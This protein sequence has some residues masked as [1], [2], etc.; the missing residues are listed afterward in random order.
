MVY[1]VAQEYIIGL[2]WNAAN[3][4]TS[5]QVEKMAYKTEGISATLTLIKAYYSSRI[6]WET[7]VTLDLVQ[8]NRTP[9]QEV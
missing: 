3:L 9:P 2:G 8:R 1:V 6:G 7:K 4:E 5:E